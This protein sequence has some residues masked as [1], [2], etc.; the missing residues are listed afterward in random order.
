VLIESHG[1]FTDSPTLLEILRQADSPS[2]ALLWDAHHTFVDGKEAPEDTVQQ[3]GRYIRHTHLKDSVPA[4]PTGKERRYVL[5]GT[6]NVPVRRQ[7]EA[8]ARI[9]Y[10]G[11][12]SFEWAPHDRSSGDRPRSLRDGREG[13]PPNRWGGR[14]VGAVACEVTRR[15]RPLTTAV[16]ATQHPRAGGVQCRA[17]ERLG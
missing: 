5:T 12:Y 15:G 17:G 13:V 14:D 7:I 8:L 3:L 2:V 9:G 16:A 11:Y 1:D 6:G 4:G 10:G